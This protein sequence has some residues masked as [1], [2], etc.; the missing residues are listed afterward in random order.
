MVRKIT[1]GGWSKRAAHHDTH[2]AFEQTAINQLASVPWREAAWHTDR[3]RPYLLPLL[4]RPTLDPAVATA[5]RTAI[6]AIIQLEVDALQLPAAAPAGTIEALAYRS[7]LRALLAFTDQAE[8][9]LGRWHDGLVTIV[10]AIVDACPPAQ[11]TGN[12]S[13]VLT[14]P[15]IDLVVAEPAEL[16][17]SLVTH[18]LAFASADAHAVRPGAALARHCIEAL[19]RTSKLTPEAAQKN[20]HRLT[21]PAQSGLTGAALVKAFLPPALAGVLTTPIPIP[22]TDLVRFENTEMTVASGGGKTVTLEHMIVQ[23]LKRPPDQV[24]AMVVIDSQGRMLDRIARLACFAPGTGALAGRLIKI[25]PT[26]LAFPPALNPFAINR[27]RL[28]TYNPV[29]QTQILNGVVQLFEF[30]FGALL[31]ADPTQR[32]TLVMRFMVRLMLQIDGSTILTLRELLDDHVPFYEQHKH[33]LDANARK[34]FDTELPKRAYRDV[35]DQVLRR[36][37]SITED[38]MLLAMFSARENK[39]DLF[40]A[41]NNGGIFLIDTAAGVLKSERSSLFGRTFLTLAMQA[42]LERAALPDERLRPT[43]L[44]L[45]E[46]HEYFDTSNMLPDILRQVRKYR[47]GI[48]ILH[49]NLAQVPTPLLRAALLGNT[50]IKIAGSLSDVDARAIAAEMACTPEF[51]TS[52]KKSPTHVN[53]AAYVRNVTPHAVTLSIPIGTLDREPRMSQASYAHLIA[54]NRARISAGSAEQPTP[55]ETTTPAIPAARRTRD[56]GRNETITVLGVSLPALLDTGAQVSAMVAT[57]RQLLGSADA[58]RVAFTI[59]TRDGTHRFERPVVD[60]RSIVGAHGAAQDC[61]VVPLAITLEDYAAVENF[62]I[63]LEAEPP[64]QPVILGQTFFAA[65]PFAA[66]ISPTD[67]MLAQHRPHTPPRA[68]WNSD[69][70]ELEV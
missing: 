34:F 21:S 35:R 53:L 47:A 42:I 43:F 27:A 28:A 52:H 46:G 38:P 70:G 66:R 40:T 11:R 23:D 51:I 7:R 62:V 39:V 44:Y 54:A 61:P 3:T 55:I 13:L 16:V 37:W 58:P 69:D 10:R 8:R 49:H 6:A 33:K 29:I 57:E 36:L 64:S 4:S 24:P 67:T 22:I 50:S 25:D 30:L 18:C 41:L 56:F 1:P 9:H 31:A 19:L 65:A 15:L 32:Q 45:D 63:T 68:L 2:T 20:P 60:T 48:M 17:A 5:I 59:A 14:A 26:D 12:A